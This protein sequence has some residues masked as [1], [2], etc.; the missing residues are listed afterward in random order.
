MLAKALAA[1]VLGLISFNAL[2]TPAEA[3]PGMWWSPAE[4]GRGYVIDA[5]G[6]RMVIVTFAYD[7]TGR[8]QWYYSPGSV[9]QGGYHF[10]GPM[11]TFDFGQPLNGVYLA[12]V[13]V[14]NAGT[15]T[16]DFT[17]RVTGTLT[18]PGGRRV[19]IQRQ[20]FGV[21]DPPGSLLGI[22][23]Y[24]YAIGS[25][26]FVDVYDFTTI[27]SAT[28]TGTG[29]VVDTVNTA[30]QEYQSSG[31]FAGQVVG[32]QFT[33]TGSVLNQ[34]LWQLQMEEGRGD[35]VSPITFNQYGMNVYKLRTPSGNNKS[36]A[37]G[38]VDADLAARTTRFNARPITLEELSAQNPELGAIA[39]HLWVEVQKQQ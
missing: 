9:E 3:Q 1:I 27:G 10:S 7:D 8:M 13:Q 32:F 14:G 23:S 17:S 16:A 4:S 15:L 30:A 28:T 39:R 24:V 22:W 35:W 20:N 29:A 34:Y 19:A 26:F 5:Q 36:L 6:D 11:L 18:L 21:G 12:P 37:P 25:T 31:T 33:S 2:A 38:K